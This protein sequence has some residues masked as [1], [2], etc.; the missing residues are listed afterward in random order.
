MSKRNK[1]VVVICIVVAAVSFMG[2]MVYKY[3]DYVP[4]VEYDYE[5]EKFTYDFVMPI[6]PEAAYVWIDWAVFYHQS[7]IDNEAFTEEMPLE[8]HQGYIL[9][10]R[11]IRE[12]F[13]EF[14]KEWG[15]NE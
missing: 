2:G 11:K 7:H 12:R 8:L 13:M 5:K 6:D 9:M 3:E 1:I 15:G 10:Y 14:E 4:I